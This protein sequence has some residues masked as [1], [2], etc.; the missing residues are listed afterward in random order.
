MTHP[1]D[2]SLAQHSV[3]VSHTFPLPDVQTGLLPNAYA[4]AKTAITAILAKVVNFIFNSFFAIEF[5]QINCAE[6]VLQLRLGHRPICVRTSA[7][8]PRVS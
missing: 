4:A 8:S 5:V 6:W 7:S 3:H 1:H 2:V